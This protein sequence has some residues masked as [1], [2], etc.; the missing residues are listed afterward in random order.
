[1]SSTASSMSPLRSSHPLLLPQ[2]VQPPTGRTIAGSRQ[3]PSNSEA[4]TGYDVTG[5]VSEDVLLSGVIDQ[6]PLGV[7][8]ARAPGCEPLFANRLF[9]EIMGIEARDDVAV[10]GYAEPYGIFGLDG[11]PYPEHRLP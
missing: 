3:C 8:L 4:G 9:R 6:L 1:A 10:G 11:E 7:W 5:T 2:L